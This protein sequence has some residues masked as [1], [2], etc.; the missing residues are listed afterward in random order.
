MLQNPQNQTVFEGQGTIL[1]CEFSGDPKPK[2]VWEKNNEALLNG[3]DN[4]KINGSQ[5]IIENARLE[6]NGL[7][8]CEASIGNI[9]RRSKK[10]Q[11][12]VQGINFGKLNCV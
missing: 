8:S 7:Y 2:V 5:L 10:G 3:Q 12:T 6:F 11:L 9:R 1:E 4:Y